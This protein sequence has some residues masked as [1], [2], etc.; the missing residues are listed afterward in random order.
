M[1][2]LVILADSA[3]YDVAC[4]SSGSNRGPRAGGLGS[5]LAPGC[6]HTFTADGR[7][8]SLLKVLMSN[9]CAFDCAYCVNR[10]SNDLPRATFTPR[11]L[12][13][14]TIEFYRRNYI[15][16]LFL[17]SAV[18]GSADYTTERMLAVLRLLR[19]EYRFN[20]YIH[21]KAIPGASPAL[22]EQL[23]CFADRLSVNIELPS[24][25]SLRLLAPD[26][27]RSS[28]LRPMG[29]I[30]AAAAANRH[31]LTVYRH[32]PV[33]APAGQSTQMIVG[34]TPESDYQILRLTEGL[35]RKYSLK[36]VFFSAYIPV[37]EDRR[38]PA[39]DTKPPLLREHRLYQAD[40]LLRFYHFRA[41]E[42]LDEGSPALSPY[43]DPKCGWAVRHLERFPVDVNRAPYE[44]LLRVPGIGVKSAQRIR[45]AR[46]QGA[47]G[48]D[49]LKRMGV[50][51]KR[52]QYFIVC[53]GFAGASGGRGSARRQQIARA[54]I[55]PGA[56]GGGC[57]QLSLFSAP[58]VQQLAAGGTP[59]RLAGRMVQE[60]AVRCLAQAL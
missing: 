17:S 27:G 3:K 26:K 20:G 46:R 23:G 6:C 56:F 10:R 49:E 53:R 57:E 4:A 28:I 32:A 37:A 51:L 25:G 39:L 22:I 50:V 15:E 47:L 45:A 60:E 7:C 43:L 58:A 48:L 16:G 29:Q 38:L 59:P 34:A 18:V 42:I 36:R 8:V 9:C 21:A 40:W 2:K 13:D 30:A 12:A 55:D 35:Y 33:F 19:E 14:L 24:E 44:E 41:D 1:E 5:C 52:A 54:L 11:E 31:D